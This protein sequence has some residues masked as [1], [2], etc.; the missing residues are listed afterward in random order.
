MHR[1]LLALTGVA[2]CALSA[3]ALAQAPAPLP[4]AAL[5][6]QVDIPYQEFTLANG[7]RVIVHAY[8]KA[9]IVAVATWYRFGSKEEA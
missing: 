1:K 6:K 9:P 3:P 2:V 5:V 7:L 4:V 8:G